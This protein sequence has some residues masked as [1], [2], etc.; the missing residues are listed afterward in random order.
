M[1][2]TQHAMYASTCQAREVPYSRYQGQ[3]DIDQSHIDALFLETRT[4]WCPNDI[5]RAEY[6]LRCARLSRHPVIWWVAQVE[7]HLMD[8]RSS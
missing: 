7:A 3:T 6:A 5:V 1:R 8:A 4:A 2:A